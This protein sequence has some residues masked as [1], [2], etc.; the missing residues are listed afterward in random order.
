[1]TGRETGPLVSVIVPTF[2]R[3]AALR[4]AAESVNAQTYDSIQLI[5]VDDSTTPAETALTGLDLDAIAEIHFIRSGNPQGAAAARNRGI[6]AADGTYVAFL[7]DDDRWDLEKIEKQVE[8]FE[9]AA[10]DVGVVYTGQRYVDEA[11]RTTTIRTPTTHGWVTK[12][13]LAGAPLAPFSTVMVRASAIEEAGTIDERFPI[14][15]D[16]EW[17][18]RLSMVCQFVAV[19]EPLV[20]RKMG[21]HGQLSSDFARIRDVSYPLFLD[22]HAPL[23]ASYGMERAFAAS[24]ARMLA[25][26]A[27]DTGHYKDAR[28]ASLRAIRA[29][30]TNG[31]SWVY[32]ALSL[33]GRFTYR[34]AQVLKRRLS[35]P[36]ASN[37]TSP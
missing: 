29:G 15:E 27:L 37:N 2:N 7:D 22:T 20:I 8:A 18:L 32:L 4:A 26:A 24:M 3:P 30:P 9:A 25:V 1:M 36:Q 5:V 11:G 28:H 31:T 6:A 17:Y 12:Q 35:T 33:G 13:L 34:L 19:P 16:R 23:A 14:W 10:P 21:D